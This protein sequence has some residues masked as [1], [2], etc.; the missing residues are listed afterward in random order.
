MHVQ[1][2]QSNW[3]EMRKTLGKPGFCSMSFRTT[4]ER[5]GFEPA[6]QCYL[7]AD[8]ANRC[9]RPLS[10]LSGGQSNEVFYSLRSTV[11][12]V[13]LSTLYATTPTRQ[14][15]DFSKLGKVQFAIRVIFQLGKAL[16]CLFVQYDRYV[17]MQL[18][19]RTGTHGRY[20]PL[21]T[22]RDRFRF[23]SPAS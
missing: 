22:P 18:Q 8:L 12:I 5:T 4:A 2:S 11:T 20:R 7:Y 9:F 6:V 10:H 14:F 1:E 19:R 23:A 17:S 13:T 15:L 16:S 3:P 21:D